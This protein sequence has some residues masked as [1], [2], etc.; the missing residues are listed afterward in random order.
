MWDLWWSKWHLDF[1][2][3]IGFPLSISF[4]RGCPYTYAY[5]TWGIK[6]GPLAA[7]VHRRRI[8]LPHWHEQKPSI[9]GGQ[10]QDS[11]YGCYT[12]QEKS[13]EFSGHQERS[14]LSGEESDPSFWWESNPGRPTPSL[15][16]CCYTSWSGTCAI[17]YEESKLFSPT[18]FMIHYSQIF[19]L[20][21][22]LISV[23][24]S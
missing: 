1:S 8:V 16:L 5:I 3:F 10:W 15:P 22:T 23:T 17:I 7:A 24:V 21:I 9:Y 19:R 13:R 18:F 2:E 12:P 14:G 4:H 6:I 20:W 11:S